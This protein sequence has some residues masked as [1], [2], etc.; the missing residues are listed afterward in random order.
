MENIM[1]EIQIKGDA[2]YPMYNFGV[3]EKP[4]I[5]SPSEIKATIWSRHPV[6]KLISLYLVMNFK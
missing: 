4:G 5:P 3:G 1:S 2:P 6:I